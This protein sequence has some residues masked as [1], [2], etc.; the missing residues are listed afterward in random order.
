MPEDTRHHF[1]DLN[2]PPTSVT[3]ALESPRMTDKGYNLMMT[4]L[5]ISRMEY[6]HF[7]MLFFKP[8]E[9]N[10]KSLYLKDKVL[11]LQNQASAEMRKFLG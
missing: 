5:D 2:I 6:H 3:A 9:I 7:Q 11:R 1:S 8:G 10:P 4:H